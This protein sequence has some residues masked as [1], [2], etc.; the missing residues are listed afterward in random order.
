MRIKSCLETVNTEVSLGNSF[1]DE[2]SGDLLSLITL[3]LN[4]L[5]ELFVVN[6]SSVASKFLLECLQQLL[7]VILCGGGRVNRDRGGELHER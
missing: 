6:E 1:L 3:K 5:T 7:E 4:D 2:E